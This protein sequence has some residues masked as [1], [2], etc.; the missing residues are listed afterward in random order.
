MADNSMIHPWP[1]LKDLFEMK[2]VSGSS[3]R[4]QCLLC[5]PKIVEV[6]AYISSPSNLKKHMMRKHPNQLEK[7]TRLTSAVQKRKKE[8]DHTSGSTSK[9]LKIETIASPFMLVSQPTV[10]K[11]VMKYIIEGL[12]PF[13]VVELPAFRDLI[14]DLQPDSTILS[15]P[16]LQRKISDAAKSMRKNLI[17]LMS[18]VQYVT[19]T[20]D[21][22]TVRR[23]SFIG[24]TAH[25]IDLKSLERRSAALAC[26]HL[27]GSPTFDVLAT[28]LTDIH[29]EYQISEKIVR[30]TTDNGSNFLKACKLFGNKNQRDTEEGSQEPEEETDE[31]ENEVEFH[32]IADVLDTDNGLEYNLPKH[33][34]CACHL[35]NLVS[36]LDVVQAESNDTYKK[37]ARS[38]FAKCQALWDK[39]GRS[40]TGA[41]MVKAECKLQFI[42]PSQT[43]WNSMFMAAERVLRILNEEGE[44]AIRNVFEA[45]K[46]NM[47]SPAELAFLSEYAMV[48][49]PVEKALNIL[50]AE[51]ST[52][53]GWLL[54][55]LYQLDSKL[56]RLKVSS[57]FCKPLVE[58]LQCGIKKRFG[59]MFED[60][61]L[62]AAAILLPK[63]KTAWTKDDAVIRKGLAYITQ[64]MDLLL[65]PVEQHNGSSDEE[66]FFASIKLSCTNEIAGQLDRYL[67]CSADSMDL[68]WSF[69]TIRE[70]SIRANTP[71]PA[72]AACERLFSIAGHLF[73]PRRA[74]LDSDNFE[75]QLLLK[76]NKHFCH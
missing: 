70:V 55:T 42:W 59:E 9:Q 60:P 43:R 7:Y 69:P 41:A 35:L 57:K 72:S 46:I 63:F 56:E 52:Q 20:A 22:W 5:L 21:C 12:Q 39:T 31:E 48:M 13:S 11:A 10:D 73:C 36:S 68:L 2:E 1:Y 74:R 16:A 65:D 67:S 32:K 33:H 66:D 30:T 53:M 49:G 27:K 47:L 38:T 3:V 64:Q 40:V 15:R 51:T 58:A 44:G 75:N 23:R 34:R 19:T 29:S 37:L 14:H 61:E 17:D 26:R 24:V 76:L 6:A 8:S 25:W 4:L 62:I 50:Q 54:P 45:L 71:L 28:A 18:E